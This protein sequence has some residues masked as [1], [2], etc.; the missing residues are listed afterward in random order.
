MKNTIQKRAMTLLLS[1]TFFASGNTASAAAEDSAE[2][3]VVLTQQQRQNAAI[4][5]SP[6][7]R[8]L[9]KQTITIQGEVKNNQYST[10]LIT[11]FSDSIVLERYVIKSARISSGDRLVKLF[12]AEVAKHQASFVENYAQWQRF[13]TLSNDVVTAQEKQLIELNYLS[14]RAT[15][16][17]LGLD[18]N[19]LNQLALNQVSAFG[20]YTL[21]ATQSGIVLNDAFVIGQRVDPGFVLFTITNEKTRWIEAQLPWQYQQ[22]I[23]VTLSTQITVEGKTFEAQLQSK[24]HYVN[25]ST[26]TTSLRFVVEDS[27]DELH[28]GMFVSLSIPSEEKSALIVPPSALVKSSDGDVQVFIEVASNEFMPVDVDVVAQYEAGIE[29]AGLIEGDK[30]VTQGAYFIASEASKNGFDTHGH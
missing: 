22:A 27:N 15:L 30:V 16:L 23:P 26:R 17:G 28:S 24:S 4:K 20:Q 21:H 11:P 18:E 2:T 5:V 25:E 12:S 7:S 14:A 19:Q 1:L 10:Q 29:V 8:S 9:Q 3:H 6:L 13:R